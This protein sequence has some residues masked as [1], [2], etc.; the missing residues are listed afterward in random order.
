MLEQ[1]GLSIP[2][3]LIPMPDLTRGG[4]EVELPKGYGLANLS[5]LTPEF[6][7]AMAV[8]VLKLIA[9]DAS[10]LFSVSEVTQANSAIQGSWPER[11]TED[12]ERLAA[13]STWFPSL[14][15]PE[16]VANT[17]FV[18]YE[19]GRVVATSHSSG[20]PR[21]GSPGDASCALDT[22]LEL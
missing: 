10:A 11:L 4:V 21:G 7:A 3:V 2:Y 6:M 8:Q 20:Q 17:A 1:K 16:P 22:D 15:L 14:F 18:M 9:G 19:E 13:A 5:S 12:G